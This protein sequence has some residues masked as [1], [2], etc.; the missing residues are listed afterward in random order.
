[1]RTTILAIFLTGLIVAVTTAQPPA[2]GSIDKKTP[3][4]SKIGGKT[5]EEWKKDLLSEDASRRAQ[6]IMAIVEF[7]EGAASAVQAIIDRLNDKDV[8]P[9]ARA[10]LALRAMSIEDKD[11]EKVVRAV[12]NRLIPAVESQAVIRYEAALT[13]YRF[14]N[15]GAPAIPNLIVATM[16]KASWEIRRHAISLLWRISISTGKEDSPPDD[17]IVEAL[18]N[19]LRMDRTYQCR[20]ETIQGLGAI[21]RP[22]NPALLNKVVSELNLCAVHPNK[23]LAIWA[24]SGLVAMQDGKP[25][26][27]ALNTLAKFLK[28]SDLETRIQAATALGALT[29]KAQSKVPMLLEMLKDKEP[30]AV[31]AA[32][33]SLGLLGDKSDKVIDALLELVNDPEPMNGASA[34]AALVNLKQRN[35]RVMTRLDKMLEKK[36][37]DRRLRFFIEEGLKELRKP[38][39][40]A[41]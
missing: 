23:P 6:A 18:L 26:E 34:V 37:L 8:S 25:A 20:L 35:S 21:G 4:P 22:G 17:R 41:S 14:V 2:T 5:L 24:Y 11:V 16:D 39:K 12:A 29:D 40:K 32:A 33:R 3:I 1:M 27:Q 30:L 36:D 28:N 31:Q 7:G 38:E 15:D 19:S 9:R 13:L 10:L